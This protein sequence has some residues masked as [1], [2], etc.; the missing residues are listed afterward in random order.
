MTLKYN[1]KS[2]QGNQAS[3]ANHGNQRNIILGQGPDLENRH[4]QQRTYS[5]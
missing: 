1:R 5:N 4:T 3:S 2:N